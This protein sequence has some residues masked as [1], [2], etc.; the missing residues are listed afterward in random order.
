MV[1]SDIGEGVGCFFILLGISMLIVAIAFAQ[2]L[3]T[4]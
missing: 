2:W 1:N 3:A 4:H